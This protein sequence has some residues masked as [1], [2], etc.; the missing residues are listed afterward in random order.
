MRLW[1]VLGLVVERRLLIRLVLLLRILVSGMWWV[2]EVW[3]VL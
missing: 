2:L 3:S 1:V